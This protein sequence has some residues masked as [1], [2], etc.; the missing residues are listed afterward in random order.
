MGI[1]RFHL[2][3]TT[4]KILARLLLSFVLMM[5]AVFILLFLSFFFLGIGIASIIKNKISLFQTKQLRKQFPI[6]LEHLRQSISVGHSL[7]Q[8]FE[9]IIPH[10]MN[11]LGHRLIPMLEALHKGISLE[12]ALLTTSLHKNITEF[13]SFALTL[14]IFYKNGTNLSGFLRLLEQ[15]LKYKLQIEERVKAQTVQIYWQAYIASI[16]PWLTLLA[17]YLILPDIIVNSLHDS[18]TQKL[19]AFALFLNFCGFLSLRKIAR[20]VL[21]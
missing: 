20:G 5:K 11:P 3:M 2:R 1:L 7:M 8:S 9:V 10:L 12:K 6:F 4:T 17:F 18:L 16:L 15:N 21:T 19:F 14:P 13:H